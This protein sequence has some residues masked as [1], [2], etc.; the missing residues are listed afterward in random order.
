MS[1]DNQPQEVYLRIPM[2]PN[3]ELTATQTAHHVAEFMQF[4]PEKID[5]IKIALIESIINAFEHSRSP[6]RYVHIWFHMRPE[7]LEVIIQDYGQGFDT[8][9]AGGPIRPLQKRGYGLRLIE[10]LMD[11]VEIYSGTNGTKVVMVKKRGSDTP[12]R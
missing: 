8:T 12:D 11:R 10:G 7:E 4:E 9:S 3:M 2:V 6:E 5:E 1:T